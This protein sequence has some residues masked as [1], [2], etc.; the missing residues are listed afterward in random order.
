V[1]REHEGVKAVPLIVGKK[2]VPPTA[3]NCYRGQYPLAGQFYMAFRPD[4]RGEVHDAIREL[5]RM[6]Y[7]REGQGEILD[8]FDRLTPINYDLAARS[9]SQITLDVPIRPDYENP[10]PAIAGILANGNTPEQVETMI[11]ELSSPVHA[12]HNTSQ[13]ALDLIDGWRRA[14][15]VDPL[16]ETVQNYD[17]SRSAVYAA[18]ALVDLGRERYWDVLRRYASHSHA[19][20][21]ASTIRAVENVRDPRAVDLLIGLLADDVR[22]YT[23]VDGPVVVGDHAHT[24]LC[25]L[26]KQ[27]FGRDAHK[28][29]AWFKSTGTKRE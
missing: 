7:S 5:V 4:A 15:L 26:T 14:K 18:G 2:S 19:D 24:A 27:D 23:T 25:K 28:W 8:S 1:T 16:V 22:L 10:P 11:L 6:T 29:R 17:D 13:V 12:N 20:M 3:E 9:A 21:R